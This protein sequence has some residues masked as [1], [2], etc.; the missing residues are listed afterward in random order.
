MKIAGQT[1]VVTKPVVIEVDY[2]LWRTEDKDYIF[3]NGS[4]NVMIMIGKLDWVLNFGEVNMA[5]NSYVTEPKFD[6]HSMSCLGRLYHTDKDYVEATMDSFRADAEKEG[7]VGL[8]DKDIKALY[9]LLHK[10]TPSSESLGFE[11]DKANFIYEVEADGG[12]KS[13]TW[14]ELNTDDVVQFMY[15]KNPNPNWV[16]EGLGV[17]L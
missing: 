13:K 15:E 6:L 9:K 5:N 17:H 16:N 8:S 14:E 11:T 4:A 2:S 3:S 7:L 12:C 1:V 10:L